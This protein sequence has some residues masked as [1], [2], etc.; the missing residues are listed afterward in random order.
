MLDAGPS[1]TARQPRFAQ[2]A[3]SSRWLAAVVPAALVLGS[4]TLPWAPS[5]GASAQTQSLQTEAAQLSQQLIQEQLQVDTLGH[6]SELDAIKV[7]EDNA[8]VAAVRRQ[9]DLDQRK[10]RA[11]RLRLAAEAVSAYVNADTNTLSQTLQLFEND[12][13]STARRVEYE[14]VAI[15][16]TTVTLA[17]LHLDQVRLQAAQGVLSARTARD[18]AAQSAA[19]AA[20]SRAEQVASELAAKQAQV[21]GQLAVAIAADRN[22]Q[23]VTAVVA[24][25]ATGGAVSDPTLPPFLQCVIEA[26][27]GGNYQAVSPNGTYMGA[28]QF[29]Q[30]TWNV[31][32]QLAGLPQLIGIP[33]NST[34]K[35]DQDTL[36][37]ALYEA[38]G[39][40]PWTGDCGT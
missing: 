35:A 17:L 12:R 23:A 25:Q 21:T 15:G 19:Q 2:L 38:D 28:F 4:S 18:E 37:V 7:A 10:V 20:V 27:S 5:A 31:A 24:R 39:S 13:L 6:Q 8:A 36:A 29:S 1:T 22:R 33:P 14:Q 11:D 16:N 32:A 26:E 34:S 9:I 3:R 40:Q 30:A